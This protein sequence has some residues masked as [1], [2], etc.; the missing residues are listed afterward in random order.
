[1]TRIIAEAGRI[2]GLGSETSSKIS[3]GF[4]P[5]FAKKTGRKPMKFVARA[6]QMAGLREDDLIIARSAALITAPWRG[7]CL[8]PRFPGRRAG[9]W[10]RQRSLRVE[11]R[12][13]SR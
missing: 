12:S 3:F 9:K 13:W 11:S 7:R 6:G 5:A 8:L 1:M 4:H 10:T 2:T